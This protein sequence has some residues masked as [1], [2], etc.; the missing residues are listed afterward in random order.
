[1]KKGGV[2]YIITNQTDKVL[3][4][5]VTSDIKKRLYEQVNKVYPDSFTAKYNCN[6]LVYYEFFSRIEDAIAKE[7]AIKKWKREWK[8]SLINTKNSEWK[9][10]GLEINNW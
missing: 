5:G 1:M 9:D 6:K 8:I 10:L 3:Y 2:V 7:K 4:V